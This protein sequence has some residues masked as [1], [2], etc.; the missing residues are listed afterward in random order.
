MSPSAHGVLPFSQT[1]DY[2]VAAAALLAV[3][4]YITRVLWHYRSARHAAA[5]ARR[6]S[7]ESNNGTRE[8]DLLAVKEVARRNRANTSPSTSG[9]QD[10]Y[11]SNFPDL[12]LPQTTEL[13]KAQLRRDKEL[14]HQLQNLELY[15]RER[16]LSSRPTQ[17]FLTRLLDS[18]DA[19]RSRL[20][21]LLDLTVHDAVSSSSRSILD[22]Q[23]Y[24]PDALRSYFARAHTSNASKYEAYLERRKEGGPRE[25]FPTREFAVQWLRLAAVVKY[26]DGG[27]IANLLNFSTGPVVSSSSRSS[28]SAPSDHSTSPERRGGKLA[29]QVISEEFGDGDLEKNHVYVYNELLKKLAPTG[30]A[31]TGDHRA[32]DGLADHEGSQRCWTA[33]IAQQC[34]GLL[35]STEDFFP[36]ALG[37][38]MAY[39]TLPYHLLVTSRELREL[40]IDDYYFAL[41]ITIDNADSGHAALARVAVEQFLEGV[42]QRDG[43]EAMELMWRRVQ[44]GV[45]LADG[46][47]TTPCGPREFK[48]DPSSR[49]WKPVAVPGCAGPAPTQVETRLVSLL[50]RKSAAA[51]KMHCPSRLLIKGRT[52]EQWLEP[53]TLT[54]EKGLE[55]LRAL[56]EKKPWVVPGDAAGS[57]LVRELEWGGRM[58]GAFSAAETK[59]VKQWVESLGQE[60]VQQQLGS[61]E[62]F[63][64]S[65]WPMARS[66]TSPGRLAGYASQQLLAVPD[67]E[68]A[69]VVSRFANSDSAS[70]PDLAALSHTSMSTRRFDNSPWATRDFAAVWFAHL[71]LLEQFPLSPTKFATPL[72]SSVLRIIRAQLGFPDLHSI[73]D[74]CAG[75]DDVHAADGAP[76]DMAGL[77]EIGH[78]C[79]QRQ[80]LDVHSYADLARSLP[81]DSGV[82]TFCADMLALRSRPYGQQALLLGLTHGF[83]VALY[84]WPAFLALLEPRERD[85]V[86][87][88]QRDVL[89]ALRECCEDQRRTLGTEGERW[90]VDFVRGHERAVREVERLF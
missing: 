8:K 31:A 88:I 46:L 43:Q 26:V 82:A 80:G 75:M 25:L 2:F 89:V 40:K 49:T 52:I 22:V 18:V 33:A 34:I 50:R 29:W 69:T 21:E 71:A 85:H 86:V 84:D 44:A 45:V 17:F 74:I 53:S 55:F 66:S 32:F 79:L 77:W 15:P 39:E 27:W 72:G 23:S 5:R 28:A 24:S 60:P 63:V 65:P 90:W 35:A 20:K 30:V 7:A 68:I 9:Q 73:E 37:F 61:Y 1:S 81:D 6:F 19:A 58:F 76:V 64:G 16:S 70:K 54:T 4:G 41:H 56:G 13:E 12:D 47:P 62:R 67:E 36:E 51:E 42:R 83:A 57:R 11:L 59:L 3:L 87:R 14:Y 78:A 48:I 10:G 38:N